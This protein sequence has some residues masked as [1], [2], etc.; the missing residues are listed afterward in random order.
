MDAGRIGCPLR[1]ARPL[2]GAPSWLVAA[3][4][5]ECLDVVAGS[6]Q[7]AAVEADELPRR[8]MVSA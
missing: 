4:A 6:S 5:E 8:A 2:L 1:V 3:R 7:L